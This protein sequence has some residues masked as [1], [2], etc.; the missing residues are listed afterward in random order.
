M[1]FWIKWWGK[2]IH[3]YS[4]VGYILSPNPIIMVH[5]IENKSLLH[6]NA[7]E[8]LITKLI[9]DRTKVM[10]NDQRQERAKLI[11]T[12]ITEYGDF[13]DKRG[14]FARD[15]IW[16]TA[17]EEDLKA[18]RWHQRYSLPVT[19]VLGKLAC[20]TLS[21][22]IG[23]GTA[24]QNWKQVKAVKLGQWVNTTMT[25]TTKQVLMYAQYQ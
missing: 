16:I 10:G 2:L 17:A 23:I 25:K 12:F 4:L 3:D 22:I 18:Y 1:Q 21:K 20:L 19:K 13:I 11:D 15:C 8:R 7:A 24:E 14:S 9:I 5:A 6:N